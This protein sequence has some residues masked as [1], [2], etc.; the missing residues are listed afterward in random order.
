MLFRG[1]ALVRIGEIAEGLSLA[2]SG[3]MLWERGGVG[4]F[5]QQGRFVLAET[6]SLAGRRDEAVELLKMALAHGHQT[7]ERWCE[8]RVHH[9]RAQLFIESEEWAHAEQCL[10]RA[11]DIAH[12]QN[13]R[14]FE[15][16][17]AA[18]LA[19]LWRDK[20][21]RRQAYDLLAPVYGEFSEGVDTPDLRQ[22][23]ALLDELH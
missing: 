9:L 12:Q 7:G 1:W 10:R 11:L 21:Q 22:A 15:I 19:R 17:S 13:A 14:S 8:A 20:G 16:R 3:L 4:A 5:L 6:C 23:K 2:R 18:S